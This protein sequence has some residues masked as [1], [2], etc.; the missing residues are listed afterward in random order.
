MKKRK[1]SPLT[2]SVYD[3]IIY[4]LEQD[5]QR[6]SLRQIADR[7]F[8]SHTTIIPHLARLE[9]M[10]WIE[11][12]IGQPRSIRLGPKAPHTFKLAEKDGDGDTA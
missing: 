3:A 1:I 9:G 11:R 2:R 8:V 6:P 12:D 10:G 5:G 7:C 4:F